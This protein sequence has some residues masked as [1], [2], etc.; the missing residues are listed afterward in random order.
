MNKAAG[1]FFFSSPFSRRQRTDFVKSS[2]CSNCSFR[3]I[4]LC[5]PRRISSMGNASTGKNSS[6]SAV[7]PRYLYCWLISGSRSSSA[8]FQETRGSLAHRRSKN[9]ATTHLPKSPLRQ[10]RASNLS[11]YFLNQG[12]LPV[13]TTR[14]SGADGPT[15]NMDEYQQFIL[16]E[17][18]LLGP[19]RCPGA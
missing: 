7:S 6:S 12:D 19:R 8:V 10:W 4:V 15:R 5:L 17:T 14:E 11:F 2:R 16:A 9:I 1:W 13:S 3:K 18:R